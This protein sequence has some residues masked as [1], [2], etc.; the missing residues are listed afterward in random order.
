[1]LKSIVVVNSSTVGPELP[2]PDVV[3]VG[4]VPTVDEVPITDKGRHW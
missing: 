1:M 3:V 4:A 2:V